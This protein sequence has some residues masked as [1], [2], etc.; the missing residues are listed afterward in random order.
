MKS[1][2]KVYSTALMK[3]HMIRHKMNGSD[4][5]IQSGFYVLKHKDK[6]IAMIQMDTF[7]GRLEYVL[8]VYLPDA[9]KTATVC[10]NGGVCARFRIRGKACVRSSA[11]QAWRQARL[12]CSILRE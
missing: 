11:G 9:V 12:F 3:D 5:E 4:P 7:T 2:D 6:D 1:R 8:A 10:Q